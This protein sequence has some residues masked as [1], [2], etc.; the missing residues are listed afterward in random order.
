MNTDATKSWI[1]GLYKYAD[2]KAKRTMYV[3][4]EFDLLFFDPEITWP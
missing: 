4:I 1:S 3:T 2:Q